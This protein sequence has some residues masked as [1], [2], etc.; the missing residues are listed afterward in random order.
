MRDIM[1][2]DQTTKAMRDSL[3]RLLGTEIP[4]TH[5]EC[6]PET[7]DEILFTLLAVSPIEECDD[8][9]RRLREKKTAIKFGGNWVHMHDDV[10][11]GDFWPPRE[12]SPL[13]TARRAQYEDILK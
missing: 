11:E 13:A 1:D 2:V 8:I 10:P 9:R 6:G 3:D 12:I 5:V 4:L 7:Y